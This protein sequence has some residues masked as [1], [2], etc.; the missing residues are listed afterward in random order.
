[1]LLR[2]VPGLFRALSV[3][4]I[5]AAAQPA[6]SALP[7]WQQQS[8]TASIAVPEQTIPPATTPTPAALPALTASDDPQPDLHQVE[9][10]AK[11]IVHEAGNQPLQGRVA[12]AQ[13]IRNRIKAGFGGD[14][15]AVVKQHGQ[16]FDV[17]AYNPSRAGTGWAEAVAIAARTLNGD[18]EE[19]APG[20]LFFHAS[21]AAMPA[22]VRVAQ[23]GDHIFYR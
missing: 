3:L 19:V 9:C 14:A 23:I 2:D 15:C 16:F 20:A 1:M 10:V 11:V 17:D 5:L 12:V 22:R 8:A 18:G 21:Y 4:A 7:Q 13:V 6:W